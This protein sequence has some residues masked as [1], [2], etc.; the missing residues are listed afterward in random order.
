MGADTTSNCS[1]TSGLSIERPRVSRVRADFDCLLDRMRRRLYPETM[2]TL[3]LYWLK[4]VCGRG[5][6]RGEWNALH[7]FVEQGLR[8]TGEN[9]AWHDTLVSLQASIPGGGLPAE[10]S[11]RASRPMPSPGTLTPYF[12]RLLNDWAP[13]EVARLSVD[14][15]EESTVETPE[16]RALAFGKALEGLL[17]RENLPPGA[18]EAVFQPNFFSPQLV[19]PAECE[20]LR[21]VL[22]YL[23]GRTDAPAAPV[24]PAALLGAAPGFNADYAQAV[25]DALLADRG[26]GEELHVPISPAQAKQILEAEQFRITSLVVSMD[27]RWWQAD[28][29]LSGDRNVIAYRPMARLRIDYSPD[30][31]HLRVPWPETRSRWSGPVSFP[32]TLELFGRR[33]HVAEWE[34]AAEHTWLNLVFA[35]PLPVEE[36]GLKRCKPAWV[37]MGWTAIENALA[38]SLIQ[39]N[40][41]PIEKLRQDDLIP[42]GRAL[43]ALMESVMTRS[44]RRPEGIEARLKGVSYH[45]GALRGPYGLV[46]WRVLPE[47]VRKVLLGRELYP[48]V[49]NRLHE[50]FDGLP[51]TSAGGP[52]RFLT[53]L[54]NRRTNAADR[55]AA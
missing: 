17:L 4:T 48:A 11:P 45:A 39:K 10:A 40:G 13:K 31:A 7:G 49:S 24:L 51:A 22:L 16:N 46:P 47:P 36:T 18:F 42:L 32:A 15:P 26:D 23:L 27:G 43:N 8:H 34:Q 29:L 38:A 5:Y 1:V 53:R 12:V 50:V 52:S 35:G 41:E 54:W 21:D 44:L 28:R 55:R 33:W 9:A 25:R 19:D 6:K 14:E 3:A 37:E 20:I 2:Q 30:G